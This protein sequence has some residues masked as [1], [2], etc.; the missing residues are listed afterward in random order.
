M[1]FPQLSRWMAVLVL[2]SWLLPAIAVAQ[3]PPQSPE[4]QAAAA[5]AAG[6]G[7]VG[8]GAFSLFFFVVVLAVSVL[9]IIGMWKV[10]EKAGKPGWASII[11][12]YN[13]FVMIQ[14]AG[15]PD[16]WLILAFIPIVNLVLVVL[17]FDI[18]EKFGKGAGFGLGLL[19][20]PLIFY[21]MLGFGDARYQGGTGAS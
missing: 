16:W 2:G 19:L 9:S 1:R 18:A 14:I 11:P 6:A 5:A 12:I 3:Q 8:C 17:P 7:C 21:P 20:L 4:E 15:R 10:F 13:V